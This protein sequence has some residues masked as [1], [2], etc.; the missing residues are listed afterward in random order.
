MPRRQKPYFQPDKAKRNLRWLLAAFVI[1]LSLPVYL[2]LEKVYS[3]LENEAWFNQRN[4]AELLID[5][6]GHR[7]QETLEEEETRPIAEYSFF[8]IL[9]SP[10]LKSSAVKLSPLSE[11]PP[12][13]NIPGLAGF[14]QINPDSSFHIP[15]L[16]DLELELQPS[17]GQQELSKRIALK[18]KLRRLLSINETFT[19]R[20]D[21]GGK[22]KKRQDLREAKAD[23]KAETREGY[24]MDDHFQ[25]TESDS[26]SSDSEQF[27]IQPKKDNAFTGSRAN[28]QQLSEEMLKELNIDADH[29]KQKRSLNET[30]KNEKLGSAS[31]SQ[32]RSR[33]EIVKLP[34]QSLAGALFKRPKKTSAYSPYSEILEEKETKSSI[35]QQPEPSEAQPP[36]EQLPL[37]ILSIESEVSPL[38][39]ILLN[40]Q[41]LCFYRRV[42][43]E[44]GRYIQG[45]IVNSR[46][47]FSAAVLPMLESSGIETFSSL[48]VAYDGILLEQ[49]KTSEEHRETLL[50]RQS[51]DPPFQR[52]ELIVNTGTIL[53]GPGAAV[54]DILAFALGLVLLGGVFLF[55]R[56][57]SR[58]IELARQQ[59][60][61]ISAVSHELKT[62]ITSIRMY[63]EMLRS[64][65]V[66]DENRKK[67]YYDYIFFESERL[68]R[69]IDNVLQL[70]R[71]ENHHE[72]T[73]LTPHD[74]Y[75]LMQRIKDK[76]QIQA[77]AAGFQLNLIFPDNRV[78]NSTILIDEDAFFQI[79]I[80]L[81][82]NAIKFSNNAA[83]KEIN[84][85]LKIASR[86]KE[87]VFY[88]RDFGPGIEKKQIKKIFRLFY[89]AGDE[90]TR[91]TTGTGIGLALVVQLVDRMNAKIDLL[92]R[93][94]GIEFQI[95]FMF[96]K[97]AY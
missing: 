60:N 94:P 78:G 30:R 20:S 6:I 4:Q 77:E 81:I 26:V 75:L 40:D 64:Q 65:W 38:Q 7:L 31:E 41:Y 87:A 25:T 9:E 59:R 56:L 58:Q 61:F 13:T 12:K 23:S 55:Y 83:K 8:N 1:A 42:W 34:D 37:K 63:G 22:E 84:I 44:N 45:F 62:P 3:Q 35:A 18:E 48:L 2:L 28:Q 17:L 14:F 93:N 85:G 96:N 49:F 27:K 69:L 32:Y 47:F 5:R 82:D 97:T 79:M 71:L 11:I 51:L 67:A 73:E 68:S 74:P 21:T 15:A 90:L 89:R 88:I 24:R 16:P 92:N 95:Q 50:Y 66:A 53:A 19:D 36:Q 46:E 39:L 33:K 70:A 54:I 86:G 10:L 91:N 80:N 72:K 29:W 52:L 57:G 76:T 43:H